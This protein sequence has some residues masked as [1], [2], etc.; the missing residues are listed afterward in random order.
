MHAPTSILAMLLLT[1]PAAVTT[2]AANESP[3][4]VRDAVLKLLPEG[5]HEGAGCRVDV[6]AKDANDLRLS[7]AAGDQTLGFTYDH[8]HHRIEK[9]ASEGGR[10]ELVVVQP[11]SDRYDEPHRYSVLVESKKV[12][13]G[14][15]DGSRFAWVGK[16]EVQ[17]DLQGRG[18]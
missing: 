6:K 14:V 1:T 15:E 4:S 2:P 8:A 11:V 13:I 5:V 7:V 18:R 3:R 12:T 17:C 16:R 10:L 9:L